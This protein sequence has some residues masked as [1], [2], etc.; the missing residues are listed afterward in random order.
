MRPL[1][2]S[3]V[4]LL[5]TGVACGQFKAGS[6]SPSPLQVAKPATES[7]DSARRI[8]RDDA[9]K[10]VEEKKAIWI[11]VRTKD[12]YDIGHIKGAMNIPLADLPSHFRDLPPKKFLITY[13]A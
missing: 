13:C 12:Q 10:M 9:I 7:L 4:V 5:T 6:P 8:V 2:A 11:D 3:F 1:V